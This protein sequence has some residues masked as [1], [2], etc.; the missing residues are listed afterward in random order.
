M[1]KLTANEI[2]YYLENNCSLELSPRCSKC[3]TSSDDIYTDELEG[4]LFCVS[5]LVSDLS[6]DEDAINEL[7]KEMGSKS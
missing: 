1:N 5:C 3:N 6:K 2:K 4:G 7:R